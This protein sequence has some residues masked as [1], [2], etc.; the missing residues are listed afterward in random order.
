MNAWPLKEP[1]GQARGAVSISGRVSQRTQAELAHQVDQ[2]A[3]RIQEFAAIHEE[4]KSLADT[5]VRARDK[6]HVMVAASLQVR[7]C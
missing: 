4:L 6:G 3:S 7:P 5:L 1:I 2:L